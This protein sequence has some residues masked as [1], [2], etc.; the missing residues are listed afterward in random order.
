MT[1]RKAPSYV[2]PEDMPLYIDFKVDI[3][4]QGTHDDYCHE[5][6]TRITHDVW[7][8]QGKREYIKRTSPDTRAYPDLPTSSTPGQTPRAHCEG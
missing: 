7:L 6:A 3:V 2:V 5:T 1:E 4:W 8:V